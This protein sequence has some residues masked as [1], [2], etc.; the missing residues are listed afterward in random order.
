MEHVYEGG[1]TVWQDSAAIVCSHWVGGRGTP[2]Q[3]LPLGIHPLTF[4]LLKKY[5]KDK[6]N[7]KRFSV[8]AGQQSKVS[9]QSPQFAVDAE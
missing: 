4:Y 6:I 9:T 2:S 5:N 8:D 3:L 1:T 7:W